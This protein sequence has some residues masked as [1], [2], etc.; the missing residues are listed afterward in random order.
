MSAGRTNASENKTWNT[1]PKIIAA[2]TSFFGIINLDPCSNND[3]FV[4]AK[5][6]ITLPQDGLQEEWRGNVFINPPYGRDKER[7]T[8]LK[9]W[10]RKTADSFAA[11]K[12]EVIML[13][14]VAT[15]TAHFKEIIFK[16]FSAL[17]F[18]SDTRLKFW[19]GGKEDPK[20][21]PM[22]CCLCYIGTR[23]EEFVAHFSGMGKCFVI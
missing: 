14:P 9:H 19:I 2:V 5:T 10:T 20:G 18:L 12:A 7:K 21:A 8:S 4:P 15:N 23:K 3:S 1:P 16:E 13:I 22:A 6:K 17:C 11:N